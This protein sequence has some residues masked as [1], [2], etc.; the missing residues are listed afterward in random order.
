MS[1]YIDVSFYITWNKKG[2][3]QLERAWKD[4][5]V[6]L[7]DQSKADQ[8]LRHVVKSIAQIPLKRNHPSRMSV[9]GFDH[10]PGKG[11]L[12]NIL[13]IPS[14]TQ[15]WPAPMFPTV[16]Y[17]REEV[18]TSLFTSPPQEDAEGDEVIPWH[19]VFQLRLAQSP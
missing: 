15:L 7:I 9:S 17:Q 14:L 4:H 1:G 10:P 11:M 12:P 2:A 13:S 8:K 5:L 16:G 18:S 3:F 6:Q 19:H